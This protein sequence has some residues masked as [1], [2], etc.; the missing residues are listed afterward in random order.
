MNK[1]L[2]EAFEDW[3]EGDEDDEPIT[4]VSKD[5][6]MEIFAAGYN[7]GSRK[8]IFQMN[9]SQYDVLVR[10]IKKQIEEEKK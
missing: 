4:D 9:K 8:N 7:M 10:M 2:D 3:W 6:A 1:E 5:R